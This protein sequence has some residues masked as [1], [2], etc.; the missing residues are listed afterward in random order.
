ME[1]RDQ[2]PT[3]L[4]PTNPPVQSSLGWIREDFQRLE[5]RFDQF[6]VS[7]DARLR[8]VE[9]DISTFKGWMKGMAAVIGVGLVLLNLALFIAWRFLDISIK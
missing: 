2:P 7:M 1:T 6:A 8:E 5:S 9:K 3:D 4:P